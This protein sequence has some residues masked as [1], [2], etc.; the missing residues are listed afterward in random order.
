MLGGPSACTTRKALG[1]G[2]PECYTPE[3]VD[4]ER[5]FEARARATPA[6]AIALST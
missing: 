2:W 3:R 5:G 6:L 4:M 1:E